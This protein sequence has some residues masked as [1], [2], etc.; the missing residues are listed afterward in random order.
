MSV[1]FA[2]FPMDW[3]SILEASGSSY[4]W[5][6]RVPILSA[7]VYVSGTMHKPH[8]RT[9]NHTDSLCAYTGSSSPIPKKWKVLNSQVTENMAST[10]GRGSRSLSSHPTLALICCVTLRNHSPSLSFSFLLCHMF[11]GWRKRREDECSLFLELKWVFPL[12]STESQL[13]PG[14]QRAFLSSD[15]PGQGQAGST[16]QLR[17]PACQSGESGSPWWTL[18]SVQLGYGCWRLFQEWNPPFYH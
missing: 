18:F 12:G 17:N 5:G 2:T 8:T 9:L 4:L 15:W 1:S 13:A 14:A 11:V 7:V 10:P 6:Q 3:T 16:S